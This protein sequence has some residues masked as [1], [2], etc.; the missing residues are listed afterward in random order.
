MVRSEESSMT[1][2]LVQVVGGLAGIG[3]VRLPISD[4]LTSRCVPM[5]QAELACRKINEEGL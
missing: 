5:L 3:S 2:W 4:P 1:K